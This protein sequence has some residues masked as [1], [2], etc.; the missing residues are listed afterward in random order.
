MGALLSVLLA[1]GPCYLPEDA[2]A[3]W[4]QVA[5]PDDARALAPPAGVPWFR[6]G[7]GATVVD[8]R[9][10]LYL[11]GAAASPGQTR[12]DFAVGPGGR[13]LDVEFQQSLRG[14]KVDVTAWGPAGTLTLLREERVGGA[15]LAL[16]WGEN[17]VEG[18]TVRVHQHLREAPVVRGFRAVRRVPAA[19]LHP[20]AAFKLARSLYYRQPPGPKVTLCQEAGSEASLPAGALGPEEVPVPVSLVRAPG[21]RA[22]SPPRALEGRAAR[23]ARRRRGTS[24]VSTA[25]Q[26]SSAAPTSPLLSPSAAS[27]TWR[28]SREAA[29][30]RRWMVSRTRA[31]IP[32]E[33]P[34]TPPPSTTI[35]GLSIVTWLAMARLR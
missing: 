17:D 21:P 13:A 31:T 23:S 25:L 19:A 9:S 29:P 30:D 16:R 18:V 34:S 1:A 33:W 4:K 8:S 24:P 5:L 28:P 12:F 15:A 26:D 6:S 10:E 20:S 11:A 7:E 2:S 14:A 22:A 35:A 32:G 3:G 27:S